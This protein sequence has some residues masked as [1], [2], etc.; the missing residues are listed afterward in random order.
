M[1]PSVKIL[2]GFLNANFNSWIEKRYHN[3]FDDK[4]NVINEINIIF[5]LRFQIDL[6]QNTSDNSSLIRCISELLENNSRRKHFCKLMNDTLKEIYKWE[7][8]AE[9]KKISYAQWLDDKLPKNL[10]VDDENGYGTELCSTD[11]ENEDRNSFK[12]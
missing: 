1:K 9:R 5:K 2:A 8:G 7:V 6:F 3:S 12:K 11:D 4:K 10:V